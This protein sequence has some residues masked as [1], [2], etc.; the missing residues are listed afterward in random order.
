MTIEGATGARFCQ[1]RSYCSHITQID[2]LD[3]DFDK[4]FLFSIGNSDECILQWDIKVSKNNWE[5]DYLPFESNETYESQREI[6]TRHYQLEKD[7]LESRSSIP[8]MKSSLVG[9]SASELCLHLQ[10]VFGRRALSNK[11]PLLITADNQLITTAGSLIIITKLPLYG[12][13]FDRSTVLEQSI[14]EPDSNTMF[15]QSPEIT[16][17]TMCPKRQMIA[18]GVKQFNASVLIWNINTQTFIKKVQIPDVFVVQTLRYSTSAERIVALCN[19]TKDFTQS[20]YLLD[21]QA[22]EIM[23]FCNFPYSHLNKIQAVDFYFDFNFKFISC[24]IQHISLWEYQGGLLVSEELPMQRVKD[25]MK[26]VKAG[27]HLDMIDDDKSDGEDRKEMVPIRATFLCLLFVD[28]FFIV[29]GEDG[30]VYLSK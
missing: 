18:I 5:L 1:S 11:L 23:A 8:S 20:L 29:G 7:R 10:K 25:L 14:C 30:E 13:S 9:N 24:G 28:Q 15:S 27:E 12:D 19:M 17:S 26:N 6:V 4:R 3:M 22:G 2:H 21:A 16:S